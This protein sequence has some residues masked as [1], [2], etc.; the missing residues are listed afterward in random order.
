MKKPVKT[1]DISNA[2]AEHG[3][4]LPNLDRTLIV[5]MADVGDIDEALRLGREYVESVFAFQYGNELAHTL[6]KL[7]PADARMKRA[8]RVLRDQEKE[9]DAQPIQIQAS[10][11]NGGINGS[12]EPHKEVPFW[13]FQLRD[14]ING[15]LGLVGTV[16]IACATY[17]GVRATFAVSDLDIFHQAPELLNT[18]PI[19]PLALSVAIKMAGGAFT[20]QATRDAYRRIVIFTGIG[21]GMIWLPLFSVQYD[22]LSGSFDPYAEPSHLLSILFNATHLLAE[23]LIGAGLFAATDAMI[24][25]KYCDSHKVDNPVRK[26]LLDAHGPASDALDEAVDANADVTGQHDVLMGIKGAA[27]I[28]V[29]TAIRQKFNEQPR[30]N[31]L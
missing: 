15:A 27:H 20:H 10:Q 18:L 12:T 16:G 30:D 8:L 7:D 25:A 6:V 17:F 23:T 2:N 22:G 29:E 31:L 9:L 28:L 1:P 11:E 14:K 21:A 24:L 26:P 19:L 3:Y 4:E 13:K 5:A